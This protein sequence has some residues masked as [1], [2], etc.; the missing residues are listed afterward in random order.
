MTNRLA[1]LAAGLSLTAAAPVAAK[2]CLSIGEAQA[3]A[4]VT[5]PDAVESARLRCKAS[6]PATSALT[7]SGQIISSR[8]KIEAAPF[9]SE[10]EQA[11][12]KISPFPITAIL[13]ADAA[14]KAARQVILREISARL[15][16]RDCPS[17]SEIIDAL[18]PLPARNVARVMIALLDTRPDKAPAHFTICKQSI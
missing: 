3:L 4:M 5:L 17:A 8:W 11:L 13:G 9:A 7:Q 10:A 12:D 2:P 1:A 6:L 15:D 18:S 16:P 14:R